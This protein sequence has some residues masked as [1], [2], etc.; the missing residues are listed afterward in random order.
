MKSQGISKYSGALVYGIC[1]SK[2]PFFIIFKGKVSTGV[3]SEQ[4]HMKEVS[5]Q[6]NESVDPVKSAKSVKEYL[7]MW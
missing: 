2:V 6:K 5:C 1:S 3:L 7:K 4:L